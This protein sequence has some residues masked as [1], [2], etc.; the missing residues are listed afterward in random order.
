MTYAERISTLM[1][2]INRLN[3]FIENLIENVRDGQEI[4]RQMEIKIDELRMEG[5]SNVSTR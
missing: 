5:M 3:H 2:E 4:V 1:E